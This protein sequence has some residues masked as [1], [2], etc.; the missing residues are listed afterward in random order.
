MHQAVPHQGLNDDDAND[1]GG[2]CDDDNDH[3]KMEQ[4]RCLAHKKKAIEES[5]SL[6]ASGTVSGTSGDVT[7]VTE[8]ENCTKAL[9]HR[10]IEGTRGFQDWCIVT[11]IDI[12]HVFMFYLLISWFK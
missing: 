11:Y 8:S 3:R 6:W 12:S 2:G 10:R 4:P 5:K 1:T 7:V 9:Q